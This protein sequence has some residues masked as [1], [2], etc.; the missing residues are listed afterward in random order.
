VSGLASGDPQASTFRRARQIA[1]AMI[2][3][4]EVDPV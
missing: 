1:E 3:N 2:V 4:N